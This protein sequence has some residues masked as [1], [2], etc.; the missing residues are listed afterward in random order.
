MI[1]AIQTHGELLHWHP[2]IHVLITC[3]AFIPDG[4]FLELPE[5]DM[6]QLLVAWQEAVFAMYLAENKIESEVVENMHSLEHRGFGVDQ[7]VFLPASDQAGRNES[8]LTFPRWDASK[9]HDLTFFD[10]HSLIPR[11]RSYFGRRRKGL[12]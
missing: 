12:S 2:H 10:A 7:S 1:G 9:T 8:Q 11:I 4:D 5:F 6:E 3:G